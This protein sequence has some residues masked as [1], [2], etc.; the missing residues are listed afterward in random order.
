MNIKVLLESGE[1]H[2]K[3]VCPGIHWID[4]G[5]SRLQY[6]DKENVLIDAT[7]PNCATLI[8][9]PYFREL[10]PS[11]DAD[12]YQCMA[13]H[14]REDG[15]TKQVWG[16]QQFLP[17]CVVSVHDTQGFMFE[18]IFD[19][20]DAVSDYQGVF[21]LGE[22]MRIQYAGTNASRKNFL[23]EAENIFRRFQDDVAVA[24][25]PYSNGGALKIETSIIQY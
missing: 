24:V 4:H 21:G 13:V 12:A 1:Y 14:I 23:N 3:G 11:G 22:A 8:I 25:A 19:G 16:F 15:N 9:F 2:L 18:G 6:S 20:V 17:K 7:R 10:S 5:R